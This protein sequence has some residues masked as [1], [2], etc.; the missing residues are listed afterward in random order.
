MCQQVVGFFS[1]LGYTVSMTTRER[2]LVLY[3][4]LVALAM[5]DPTATVQIAKDKVREMIDEVTVTEY[6]LHGNGD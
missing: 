4:V 5:L 6:E 3:E 2:K 1:T